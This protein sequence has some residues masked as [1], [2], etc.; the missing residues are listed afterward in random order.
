MTGKRIA[1]F[2]LSAALCLMMLAGC[3]TEDVPPTPT[4]TVPQT[5]S[6][7][8]TENAGEG[9]F[10]EPVNPDEVQISTEF[11]NLYF[12]EQW[13]EFMHTEQMKNDTSIVVTFE[14]DINGVLYPLFSITIGGTEGAAVGQLT[15][16]AGTKRNVYVHVEEIAESG[17]L[18]EGE[19]NRMYAMQ[20]EI[21]YI[22]ERLK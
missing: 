22:I 10:T 12:R 4:E 9:V 8:A 17:S 15:D 6:T 20:E 14:A 3:G 18:T 1:A 16:E 11:G 19:L 2:F 13:I 5:E 7:Q 21:N